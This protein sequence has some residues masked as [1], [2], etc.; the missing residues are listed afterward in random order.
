MSKTSSFSQISQESDNYSVKVARLK[1]TKW[2]E[3]E[4]RTGNAEIQVYSLKEKL[5]KMKSGGD[6]S[7]KSGP[8]I[9]RQWNNVVESKEN[10]RKWIF[11]NEKKLERNME[12]ERTSGLFFVLPSLFLFRLLFFFFLFFLIYILAFL[13]TK[14]LYFSIFMFVAQPRKNRSRV[15]AFSIWFS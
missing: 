7:H 10:I 13:Q 5:R 12:V 8:K 4:I 15:P 3:L 14:V 2:Q 11:W 9:Q 6:W 1:R